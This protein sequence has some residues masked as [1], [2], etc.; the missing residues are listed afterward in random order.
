M[1][2]SWNIRYC[3]CTS[4]E[5]LPSL[6]HLSPRRLDL[7]NGVTRRKFSSNFRSHHPIYIRSY[8]R[9]CELLWAWLGI[10]WNLR[11]K[12]ECACA[13]LYI[14]ISENCMNKFLSVPE[15]QGW[16]VVLTP[17]LLGQRRIRKKLEQWRINVKSLVHHVTLFGRLPDEDLLWTSFYWSDVE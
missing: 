6:I 12:K 13:C 7:K 17:P 3:I 14:P 9:H 4:D 16:G 10:L 1:Y 5:W 2:T 11:D 8:G 15:I